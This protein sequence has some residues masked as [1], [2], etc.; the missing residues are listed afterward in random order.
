MSL[1]M[2]RLVHPSGPIGLTVLMRP[3]L[4]NKIHCFDIFLSNKRSQPRPSVSLT[5]YVQ[6]QESSGAIL[7]S[8]PASSKVGSPW[9][10]R[11][12]DRDVI[13]SHSHPLFHTTNPLALQSNCVTSPSSL[14]LYILLDVTSFQPR[15][16]ARDT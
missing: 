3:A 8:A 1:S 2:K 11:Y 10:I 12:F 13:P 4:S 9:D 14:A 6:S 15:L 16:P 7:G 5:N